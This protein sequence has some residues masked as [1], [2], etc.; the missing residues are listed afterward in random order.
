MAD[1]YILKMVNV[2]KELYLVEDWYRYATVLRL[3]SSKTVSK[4][5]GCNFNDLGN[6]PSLILSLTFISLRSLSINSR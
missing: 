6:C 4:I 2:A 5:L 1:P 3:A